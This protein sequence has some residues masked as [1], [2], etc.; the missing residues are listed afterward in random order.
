[1]QIISAMSKEMLE[2]NATEAHVQLENVEKKEGL[3]AVISVYDIKNRRI[4]CSMNCMR[5]LRKITR[6]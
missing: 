4:W 6:K 3:T 2:M 5:G 1:M